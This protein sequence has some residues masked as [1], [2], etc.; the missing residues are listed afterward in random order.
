[1][2]SHIKVLDLYMKSG[3]YNKYAQN[4]TAEIDCEKLDEIFLCLIDQNKLNK[5]VLANTYEINLCTLSVSC[6][7]KHFVKK[8]CE[9]KISFQRYNNLLYI[10]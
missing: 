1:M 2:I 9:W 5:T 3:L 8:R 6:V 7:V 10:K 4:K